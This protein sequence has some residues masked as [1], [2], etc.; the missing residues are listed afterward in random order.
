MG[1]RGKRYLS[2]IKEVDKSKE[3]SPL[4]AL[5]LI[6]RVS[7]CKFTE[8]VEVS[9][10]LNIKP[11]ERGERVRGT[12]ALPQ[13]LGKKVRVLVFT[14]GKEAEEAKEKGADWTGG[15]ELA[16]RIEG[17]W[18]DFDV[19]VSTPQMMKVVAKLGRILGPQGLMPSPK[20][21]T[22]SDNPAQVVEELK[23]GKIE[24]RNDATG[25]IHAMIGKASFTKEALWENLKALLISLSK[26]K[27][28][29][30]KG[31]YIKRITLCSTMGPGINLNLQETLGAL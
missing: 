15:E 2:I 10:C 16:K 1:K 29:T 23:K 25:V 11:K 5:K 8:S 13:G 28:P 9:V 19:V 24:Y 17:G 22:V 3:Y 4:E 27:P 7:N 20:V 12:V 31:R 30:V 6:K 21:G 26:N 14:S 18:L